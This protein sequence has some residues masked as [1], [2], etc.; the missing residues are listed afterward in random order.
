MHG[1][2]ICLLILQ[3]ASLSTQAESL[4]MLLWLGLGPC[5]CM[6]GATRAQHEDSGGPAGPESK[7]PE[8][9]A[10]KSEML[11]AKTSRCETQTN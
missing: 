5:V 2:Q 6:Q 7:W 3:Q 11:T 8:G 4:C 10:W 1:T 9:R